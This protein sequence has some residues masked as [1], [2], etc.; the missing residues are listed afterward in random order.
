[1]SVIQQ[2]LN[3]RTVLKKVFYPELWSCCSYLIL[4]FMDATK[5]LEKKL[6]TNVSHN[7]PDLN[8]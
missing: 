6:V 1:M 3:K 5:N 4:K 2:V 7:N 8:H